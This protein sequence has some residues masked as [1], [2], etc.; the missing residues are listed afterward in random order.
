[1]SFLAIQNNV[2]LGQQN[3]ANSQSVVLA[4]DAAALPVFEAPGGGRTLARLVSFGTLTP[5]IL[6][7][8]AVAAAGTA[9]VA[10]MYYSNGTTTAHFLQIHVGTAAP[11]AGAVPLYS[12]RIRASS[13]LL[14][15]DDYWNDAPAS[16]LAIGASLYFV[17]SSTEGTFTGVTLTGA[18]ST[19]EV[20][21]ESTL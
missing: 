6:N 17:R 21:V 15:G 3:T 9:K 11:A 2:A 14:I 16:A 7:S 8:A 5:A 20:H 1:M 10:S 4:S 19:L 13:D 18:G 12:F